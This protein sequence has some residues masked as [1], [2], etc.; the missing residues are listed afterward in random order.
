MLDIESMIKA[1]RVVC[2]KKFLEDYPSSWKTILTVILTPL[3]LG[4]PYR[5]ITRN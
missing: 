1:K 5:R 4:S 3:S 2:L